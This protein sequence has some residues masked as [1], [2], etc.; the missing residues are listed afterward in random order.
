MT[1]YVVFWD[2]DIVGTQD[3]SGIVEYDSEQ[4]AIDDFYP[5]AMDWASNW[6]DEDESEEE[7]AERVE[8]WVEEYDPEKHDGVI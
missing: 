4:E 1:K 5:V 2:T 6:Q 8:I 3:H 7:L